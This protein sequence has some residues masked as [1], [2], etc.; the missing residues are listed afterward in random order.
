MKPWKCVQNKYYCSRTLLLIGNASCLLPE[1]LWS[2]WCT[3]APAWCWTWP[4]WAGLSRGTA[5]PWTGSRRLLCTAPQS[6]NTW[7]SDSHWP[8]PTCHAW[9]SWGNYRFEIYILVLPGQ[10]FGC[11]TC[12]I[13][14]DR[15]GLVL[16]SSESIITAFK[17]E[18]VFHR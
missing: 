3:R 8:N 5:C 11:R 15:H 4:S 14:I 2:C 7:W 16:T 9:Q 6:W 10:I 17:F 18:L 12:S 13:N 1:G